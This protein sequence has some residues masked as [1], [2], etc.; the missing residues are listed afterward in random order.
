MSYFAQTPHGN[1][2]PEDREDFARAKGRLDVLRVEGTNCDR[3]GVYYVHR[4][5]ENTAARA[6]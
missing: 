2:T 1:V 5:V 6:T 4:L 3:R